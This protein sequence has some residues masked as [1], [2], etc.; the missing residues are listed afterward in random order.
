MKFGTFSRYQ[1]WAPLALWNGAESCAP[2]NFFRVP[3]VA[4]LAIQHLF[5]I[6]MLVNFNPIAAD[7]QKNY[8]GSAIFGEYR[9]HQDLVG[10]LSPCD[11][12][13]VVMAFNQITIRDRSVFW[14]TK[15]RTVYRRK[16]PYCAA[17]HCQRCES[18]PSLFPTAFSSAKQWALTTWISWVGALL[19]LFLDDP[20]SIAT[21]QLL[22]YLFYTALR[23]PIHISHGDAPS[24]RLQ[25]IVF[26]LWRSTLLARFHECADWIHYFQHFFDRLNKTLIVASIVVESRLGSFVSN[27]R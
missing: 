14:G 17:H 21:V 26:I 2:N 13:F 9:P 10:S 11:S 4:I 12:K 19:V 5:L 7:R 22:C 3:T 27:S 8:Q 15:C 23:F 18:A 24:W 25:C 6:D 1:F 16:T 20:D